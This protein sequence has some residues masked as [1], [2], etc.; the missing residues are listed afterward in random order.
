MFVDA[1]YEK[2]RRDHKVE[3]HAI[4]IAVG[5]SHHGKRD[6]LGVDVCNTEND[7]NWSDF[8]DSL[9]ERGLKGVRLVISDAHGGLVSAIER[10][11]PGCQWH[12]CQTHPP[13]GGNVLDKVRKK[14]KGWIKERLDDIYSA[15]DKQ[16]AFDR[17]QTLIEELSGRYPDVVR[18]LADWNRVERIL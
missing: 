1:R 12:R 14:D 10:Y 13:A 8:F 6:I 4:L 2:I 9:V 3:S 5:V 7:T 11:F 18:Q 17:L 15:G 16:T